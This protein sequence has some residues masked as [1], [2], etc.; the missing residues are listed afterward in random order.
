MVWGGA[1]AALG[2]GGYAAASQW[3]AASSAGTRPSAAADPVPAAATDVVPFEGM[4]Q[5]GIATPAQSTMV[6]TAYDVENSANKGELSE[7]LKAWTNAARTLTVGDPVGEDPTISAGSGA[8]NLTITVGVGASLVAGIRARRPRALVDLPSFAGDKID[9][10]RSGG[11]VVVQ[12]CADDPLVLAQAD[13]V[14]T[15]LA[16]GT[17]AVRWQEHGFGSTGARRDGRTGRNLMGQL[18]GTNN[19]TTS[20][21]ATSGPIWVADNEPAWMSAGSYLVIRRIRMLTESWDRTDTDEQERVIG[22]TKGAGAPLGSKMET[23]YVDL[24]A[25]NADG[26]L[27]IPANSHVRQTTPQSS[28]ENMMRRGYSY[29]G[30]VLSDGSVDQGLLFLAYQKDPTTSFI[31]VQQRMAAHDALNE[32][33]VTTGS[34]VFAIL[35]GVRSS[36]DWL[37]SALFA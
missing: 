17:L 7:V 19:V 12:L 28:G 23:D 16:A 8:A 11:D 30:P 31:P 3:A 26:A 15:R 29:R 37:G 5:A 32:F 35:P 4:H 6:L 25:R 9:P 34:A 13:R 18:D 22:R 10:A 20:Q 27:T 24:K 33:T 1:V 2:V 21:L 14:L 36:R